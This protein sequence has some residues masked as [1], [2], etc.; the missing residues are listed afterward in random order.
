MARTKK[1]E[2]VPVRIRFKELKNGNKSIYLDIYINGVRKYEFLKL[3]LV[4][5]VSAEARAK[6][7][8][9][10]QAANAIKAQRILDI[11]NKK[12]EVA[13]NE[14]AK[15]SL[16][17]WLEEYRDMRY[18][19]GKDSVL[20]S[21]KSATMYLEKYNRK[22]LLCDVDRDFIEGFIGFLEGVR[23]KK[24]E[25]QL[26]R[27]TISKHCETI[28]SALNVAVDMQILSRNPVTSFNWSSIGGREEMKREYLTIDELKRLAETPCKREAVKNAFL[29]S[30]FCG[31]RISDVRGLLWKNIIPEGAKLNIE[32]TQKKTGTVVYFPL[33]KP[34]ASYLPLQR[35]LDT[36]Y[37]F[38]LCSDV[39]IT[40]ALKDWTAAAG[41]TKHVT[42]HVAR[43]TFATLTLT[44]GSDIYTTSQLMGH[45]NVN[46]TQIYGKIIDKKKIEAVYKVD[47][48]F[49]KS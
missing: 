33:S 35:G 32:F 36:D 14:K 48:L 2:S 12:P 15:I 19:L 43:H 9:T 17:E 47:N 22:V 46:V 13:L 11:A 23:F 6:N 38:N 30:C 1:S 8:H 34:A 44:L 18:R 3:F 27:R 25:K 10:M 21:V 26:S 41:I 28:R 42:F 7:E 5:E 37:V 16:I 40:K 4:P 39:A 24:G 20:K 29:F 49:N 31:L 45:S